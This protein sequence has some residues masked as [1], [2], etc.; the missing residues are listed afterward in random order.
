MGY[1][2]RA[3]GRRVRFDARQGAWRALLDIT[4]LMSERQ[5]PP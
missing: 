1:L 5:T 4:P 2:K 3:K